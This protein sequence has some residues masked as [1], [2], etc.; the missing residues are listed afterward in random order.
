M[1][2][3]Q[4][5]T[6]PP[7]VYGEL[8]GRLRP[9]C[10]LKPVIYGF[11]SLKIL[12]AIAKCWY[13]KQLMTFANKLRFLQELSMNQRTKSCSKIMRAR[14]RRY[15]A[16]IRQKGSETLWA[17]TVSSIAKQG[18]SKHDCPWTLKCPDFVAT[19]GNVI[20]FVRPSACNCPNYP[21]FQLLQQIEKCSPWNE[22][23]QENWHL[24][25][26][27]HVPLNHQFTTTTTTSLSIHYS[28]LSSSLIIHPLPDG[29]CPCTCHRWPWPKH[30][31]PK[32]ER[33]TQHVQGCEAIKHLS[34]F[35]NV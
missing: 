2:L 13:I 16:N 20:C 33:Q 29:T 8:W 25:C 31:H 15:V 1:K 27:C 18:C 19:L 14:S 21:W 32:M 28:L 30:R 35:A 11:M 34:W 12:K 7:K 3:Q 24:Q 10:N 17:A 23:W 5:V 26:R 4:Q 6:S 9:I 22:T